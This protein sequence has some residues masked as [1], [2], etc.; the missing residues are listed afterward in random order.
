M[1]HQKL[2]LVEIQEKTKK[3]AIAQVIGKRPLPTLK[4]PWIHLA[5]SLP[6][7]S[8][9]E[10]VLE[11]SVEMGVHSVHPFTSERSFF[12]DI[13]KISSQRQKRWQ[14][15]ILS[16]CEQTGRGEPLHLS[17]VKTFT[18][19]LSEYQNQKNPIGFFFYEAENHQTLHKFSSWNFQKYDHLWVF[20][21]SEGGFSKKEASELT[22][23]H[24]LNLVTLGPQVL[25]VETACVYSIGILKYFLEGRAF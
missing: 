9:F 15:Q 1:E 8:T 12:K 5:L 24:G 2:L 19:L 4:K 22:K 25:R 13:H 20:I 16:A 14:K 23:K 6:K 17:S 11:K 7:L 21:G 10:T 18:T 3:K